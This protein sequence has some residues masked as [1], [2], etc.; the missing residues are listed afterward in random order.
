MATLM[1]DGGAD[2]RTIRT[3]LGHARLDT[4][5][6]YTQVSLKK[7]LDTHRKTHPAEQP[8]PPANPDTDPPAAPKS[9]SLSIY[10]QFCDN[11]LLRS[12]TIKAM[13]KVPPVIPGDPPAA[14][15]CV[16]KTP[17]KKRCFFALKS[18]DKVDEILENM[19]G[20]GAA[21]GQPEKGTFEATPDGKKKILNIINRHGCCEI[22][23][24]GHQGGTANPGGICSKSLDGKII[25]LFPDDVFE[26]TNC[27]NNEEELPRRMRC[28]SICVWWFRPQ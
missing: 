23:F 26:D 25:P 2:I 11:S 4:T 9:K 14:P 15:V 6:I 20:G 21:G 22:I 7:L 19:G 5:Q 1:H 24:A 3:I 10:S 17:G 12:F 27:G 28:F 8:E 18:P 16:H 13:K